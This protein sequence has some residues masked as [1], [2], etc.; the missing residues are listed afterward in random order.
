[1]TVNQLFKKVIRL[2]KANYGVSF[3]VSP[4]IKGVSLHIYRNTSQDMLGDRY[5]TVENLV[6]PDTATGLYYDQNL[7]FDKTTT[8]VIKDFLDEVER[9]RKG[10]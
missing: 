6:S 7:K 10:K 5:Y 3:N 8:K 1:M 9:I 2:N 4:H